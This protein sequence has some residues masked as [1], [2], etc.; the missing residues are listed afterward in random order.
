LLLPEDKR[1]DLVDWEYHGRRQDIRL[2]SVASGTIEVH[3]LGKSSR[4]VCV[5]NV[6]CTLEPGAHQVIRLK[7]SV[8]PRRKAFFAKD[9]LEE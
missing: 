3:N 9:F 8:D 1:V 2:F 7:R 5:N 6:R 4:T